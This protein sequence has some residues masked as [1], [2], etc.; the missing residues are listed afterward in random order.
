MKTEKQTL[1]QQLIKRE[2]DLSE[3]LREKVSSENFMIIIIMFNVF[4][5]AG[6][7]AAVKRGSGG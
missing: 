2:S 1:Q 7:A 5:I 6:R 3:Q 4:L